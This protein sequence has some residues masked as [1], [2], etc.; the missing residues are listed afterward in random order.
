MINGRIRKSLNL[1]EWINRNSK[2]LPTKENLYNFFSSLIL[3]SIT[4]FIGNYYVESKQQEIQ[5]RYTNLSTLTKNRYNFINAFT[6]VG[7]RRV[8]FSEKYYLNFVAGETR[9]TLDQTWREYMTSVSQWNE[10]NLLNPL[11]LKEYFGEK[12]QK[13]YYDD[14]LP[15]MVALH[16]K[17]LDMRNKKDSSRADE[18]IESAKHELFIFSENLLVISGQH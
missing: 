6:V 14:L 10:T 17:M 18:I 13:Q 11:F 16:E 15:K 4:L 7:Q 1:S 3:L 2:N 9:S 8:Y 5:Q 12:Y